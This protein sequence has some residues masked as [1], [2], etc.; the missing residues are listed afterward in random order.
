MTIII[1]IHSFVNNYISFFANWQTWEGRKSS[2]GGAKKILWQFGSKSILTRKQKQKKAHN[3]LIIIIIGEQREK[4]LLICSA[5]DFKARFLRRAHEEKMSY[6]SSPFIKSFLRD[7]HLCCYYCSVLAPAG[8][9]RTRGWRGTP[10]ACCRPRV[11]S[12]ATRRPQR[13]GLFLR[14]WDRPRPTW[15]TSL[16]RTRLTWR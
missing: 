12:G 16:T 6:Y 5:G 2:E 9:G 3:A 11:P 15:S 8:T 14:L 10:S 1:I 4:K 13:S 7:R